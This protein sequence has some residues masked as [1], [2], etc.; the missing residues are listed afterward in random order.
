MNKKVGSK[1]R[2][3]KQKKERD[4]NLGTAWGQGFR[5]E[6]SRRSF[7]ARDE[8]RGVLLAFGQS[9][10]SDRKEKKTGGPLQ[11]PNENR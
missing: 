8:Q 1:S 4:I 6:G 10:R 11:N 3:E 5:F 9:L 2:N 7:V